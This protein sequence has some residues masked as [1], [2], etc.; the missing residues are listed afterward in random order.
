MDSLINRIENKILAHPPSEHKEQVSQI[1]QILKLQRDRIDI[2]EKQYDELYEKYSKAVDD[3][4]RTTQM[5]HKWADSD[6]L[7]GELRKT[8]V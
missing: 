6:S 4:F 2:L 7:E 8:Q 5:S 3:R 1:M